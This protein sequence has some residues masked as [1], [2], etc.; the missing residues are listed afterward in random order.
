MSETG[1]KLP[2]A[3]DNLKLMLNEIEQRQ[4]RLLRNIQSMNTTDR[5]LFEA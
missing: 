2:V 3:T 5:T 4:D 1:R